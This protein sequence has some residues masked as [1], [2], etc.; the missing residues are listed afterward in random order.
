[1]YPTPE[2]AVLGVVVEFAPLGGT[3][4]VTRTFP[5]DPTGVVT[6]CE[7]ITDTFSSLSVG[8]DGAP[9]PL[10]NFSF[11]NEG[12]FTNAQYESALFGIGPS[13][14][15]GVVTTTAGVFDLSGI[16]LNNYLLE[17]SGGTYSTTG[18]ILTDT[19][20]LTH[21]HEYYGH[22]VYTEDEAGNCGTTTFSD[23]NYREYAPDVIAEIVAQYGDTV[24]WSQYDADGDHVIDLLV[25][26]HAGY[27]FQNGGGE[28]RL[29]TSSSSLAPTPIQIGGTTTP[30]IGDDYYVEGFNVDPEQLDVGAIQEEFEHQ[31]GLPD[32]YTSQDA[33]DNS[34]A[35]WAAHSAGVW[36]GPLGGTRPVGHNL[37][38]DWVLGWRDPMVI[39]YDDASLMN[40]GLEVDLGRAR[41]T[42]GGTE[43]GVIV[44]LPDEEALVENR[45][46][47]GIG[48]WSD[49]G[50]MMDHR[51]YRDFDLTTATAP[52]T[53]TF[54]AFW[55]IEE[56]WDYGFIE[57]STDGGTTWVSQEDMDGIL[58]D[59]DPN[60]NNLGWGLTDGGDSPLRF[61]LSAF[62]GQTIGLR[63]RYLTDPAVSN[64]GWWVDDL[65]IEDAGGVVY[66]N[67]LETDFS[68]WTVED[69]VVVPFTQINE[70]FYLVEWRDDNGFDESLNDPYQGVYFS[71]NEPPPES[72]VDR[73]P[74]TTPG[75]LLAY[76]NTGQGFDYNL[77]DSHFDSP[78]WGPKFA[79][80]VVES[81]TNPYYF[82]TTFDSIATGL[83][84]PRISGR[85]SPGD[86]VFGL[87]PTNEW[88]SRLGFDYDTGIYTTTAIETKTWASRPAVMAFHDSYGY[89]PGLW[90]CDNDG[91][92]NWTDYDASA[93]LPAQG[94]FSTRITDVDGNPYVG[95]Y[96]LDLGGSLL[97]TGNPGDDHVHFGLHMEVLASSPS[98]GT[99]KI[100]NDLYEVMASA[101]TDLAPVLGSTGT[102]TF[103]VDENIGGAVVDPFIV[104]GLPETVEYVEGS[105]YG[106]MEAVGG[107]FASPTDVIKALQN[108]EADLAPTD[109]AA[110]D[111]LVWS[112]DDIGTMMGT[113][114]FGFDAIVREAGDHEFTIWYFRE[115]TELFQTGTLSVEDKALDNFLH[116]PMIFKAYPVPPAQSQLRAVHASPDAPNVDVLVDGTAAYTNVAF[117]DVA[118]YASVTAGSHDIV[119]A[120]TGTVTPVI[121]ATLDL[122][123]NKQYTVLAVGD[124]ATIEPLVLVD[125]NALPAAGFAHV[126]FVHASPDAPA[127]DVTGGGTVLFTN[128]AFKGVGD[129]FPVA[130]GEYDLEVLLA[131]TTTVALSVPDVMLN[132]GTVYTI[133]AM[134]YA[135]GTPA[136]SAVISV[137]N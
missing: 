40:G 119:I 54:G 84:G 22:A 86:A 125:N 106:G 38:Q 136:L 41:Y 45:A 102:L 134:G 35:W 91:F 94:D 63:L 112:G 110:V 32:M 74:A 126:R 17:M 20:T 33:T 85:V 120:A 82:D 59:T 67:D 28:D 109:V 4:E 105:A 23:A 31:F 97:G 3:E 61:D 12:G 131:G 64:P 115:G 92:F 132:D 133:Y 55:D 43:D 18:A 79:H 111:Y 42:P 117:T 75:M 44:M 121:S 69:W 73:L 37:W 27:G 60:G 90:C 104:V 52:I 130:A 66:E 77:G 96:G 95:L 72:V 58:R 11:Y 53:F 26:I 5:I 107:T 68:D 99:V 137:D 113:D 49:S 1:M 7:V 80:L 21:T 30:G 129:Y 116:L 101:E 87:N 34:N 57:V 14:G 135:S 39:D 2:K 36:G 46:G 88:I 118:A 123:A 70:R 103:T 62:A 19:V 98:Q 76:R 114:P 9:G 124:L 16:S 93:V 6:G 89:F 108:G 47:S 128:V 83:I 56:D 25:I 10:D 29:S 65:L 127:V 15:Y 48:W 8:E 122:A 71:D 78:S 81:N 51:V 50:D 13:A 100:W 24:D